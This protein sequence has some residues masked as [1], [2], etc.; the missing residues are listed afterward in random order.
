MGFSATTQAATPLQTARLE[1]GWKQAQTIHALRQAASD[2]G[3][4]IATVRSLKTMLSRWENGHDCPD[5]VSQRLLC[6]IYGKSSDDLGFSRRGQHVP[7]L[8][9]VASAVGP[10][11]VQYFRNVFA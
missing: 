11:L 1:M 6:R 2:E 8:P 5:A 9:R 10:E 4:S 7:T 3:L